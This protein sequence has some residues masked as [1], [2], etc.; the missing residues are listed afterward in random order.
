MKR[1]P[2][3]GLDKEVDKFSPDK[4]RKDGKAGHCRDCN[5]TAK[6]IWVVKNLEYKR[7]QDRKWH[8][9]NNER[10]RANSKNWQLNNPELYKANHK[11][12]DRT[13]L[14]ERANRETKRRIRTS[15][16]FGQEGIKEFY[17]SRPLAMEI[18]HIIPL[19]GKLV[20]GLHVIWNLQYLSEKQNISKGN[21]INLIA[22]TIR[23]GTVLENLGFKK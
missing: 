14:A 16:S 12:Y 7:E 17:C 3:C 19:K 20:S 4:S 2:K 13:H 23:Y 18:D 5:N 6:N 9:D 21:R 11:K 1:C 15:I 8:Q 22:E 10:S